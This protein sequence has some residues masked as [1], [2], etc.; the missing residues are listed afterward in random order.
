MQASGTLGTALLAALS[1][2]PSLSLTILTRAS[3]T[4]SHL[5]PHIPVRTVSPALTLAELTAA[6]RGH[7]AVVN[8]LTTAGDELGKRVV[9]ACVAAGVRRLVTGDFGGDTA[10]AEARGTLANGFLKID[11]RGRKAKVF[12]SGTHKFTAVTLANVARATARTLLLDDP[13][14]T[15]NRYL[16]F[17]D[18]ACSQRDILAEL[19]R[20][21]GEKW[22]VESVASETEIARARERLAEGDVEAGY[23]LVAISA[24][25][26]AEVP[27]GT[28]F[29]ETGLELANDLVGGLPKVTLEDVVKGVLE[30][31]H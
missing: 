24:V 25:G 14:A 22:T 16:Y 20:Q 13:A 26:D 15:A 17:Q 10:N 18:F 31:A 4:P 6:F 30:K 2:H 1:T 9:D 11:V 29:E 12:D 23:D 19:E 21:T 7:D 27:R 8:A 28:W 3:S 5:P